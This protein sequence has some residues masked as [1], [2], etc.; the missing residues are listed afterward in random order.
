MEEDSA[1]G[2][3]TPQNSGGTASLAP[4]FEPILLQEYLDKLLPLLL[5][6]EEKELDALWPID[7]NVKLLRK[8]ANDTSVD[9]IYLSKILG[10]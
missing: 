5:G 2:A 4:V 8:F 6:A 1:S 9:A 3:E 7:E 10:M